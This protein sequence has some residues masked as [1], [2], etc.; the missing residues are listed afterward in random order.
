MYDGGGSRSGGRGDL[1]ML[2]SCFGL[3]DGVFVFVRGGLRVVCRGALFTRG[4]GDD[5]LVY[6]TDGVEWLAVAICTIKGAVDRA[7]EG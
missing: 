1:D 7:S 3:L 6:W 5:A 4:R 2:S